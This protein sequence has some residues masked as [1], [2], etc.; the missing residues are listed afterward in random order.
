[1]TTQVQTTM[2]TSAPEHEAARTP[3]GSPHAGVAAALAT[4][5]WAAF[6][7]FW[8]IYWGD[9]LGAQALMGGLAVAAAALAAQMYL[10]RAHTPRFTLTHLRMGFLPYLVI[11]PAFVILVNRVM[12]A[13]YLGVEGNLVVYA[14]GCLAIPALVFT[15]IHLLL[16]NLV[17]EASPHGE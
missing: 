14:L 12:E 11:I 7:F 15:P 6:L 10:V 8:G 4:L 13:F 5:S 9:D 16:R 1:M 3:V 17:R 2:E